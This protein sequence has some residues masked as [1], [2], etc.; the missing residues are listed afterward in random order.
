[1]DTAFILNLVISFLIGGTWV[2]VFTILTE[3][4]GTKMGGIIACLPS[5]IAVSVV[6]IGLTQ[7]PVFAAEAMSIIPAVMAINCV[8]LVSYILLL[9]YG[10]VVAPVG[11]LSGWAIMALPL[12]IL[13]PD[14]FLANTLFFLALT[15]VSFYI[16]Q[17]RMDHPEQKAGRLHYRWHEVALRGVVAGSAIAFAVFISRIGGPIIGGLFSAFPA[18][19][20]STMVIF[21]RRHGAGFAGAMGKTMVAGAID[22][23]VFAF[24]IHITYPI[25]GILKGT[26]IAYAASIV[27]AVGLYFFVRKLK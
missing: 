22:I 19:F 18:I 15:A 25:Y 12:A 27:A 8:F 1:M 21:S 4:L 17:F 20:L 16:M 6:F 3:R 10:N 23:L 24:V 7:T 2:S 11:A 26:L 14:N 13:K 5:T 9:N